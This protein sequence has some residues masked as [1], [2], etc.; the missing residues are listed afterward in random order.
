METPI[1]ARVA[2]YAGSF[3]PPTNGHID[4]IERGAALYDR[5]VVAVLA[6]PEKKY[7]FSAEQRVDMLSRALSHLSNVEVIQDG[8][9]LIDVARR[10]GAGVI[11]RGVRGSDD[12]GFEMQLAVANRKL[13]G[14]E[15][16]FLPASPEYGYLSSSIVNGYAMHGGEIRGMVPEILVGDVEK[17][18]RK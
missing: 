18:H 10:V 6:N 8:G 11:L 13:S 15:T 14:V 7:L 2:I 5:L 4:I 3:S 1:S 17:A 9:L 16:V 12:L